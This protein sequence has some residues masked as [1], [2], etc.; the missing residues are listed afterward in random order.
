M[1]P[2]RN[3]TRRAKPSFTEAALGL[4]RP[5]RTMD[6]EALDYFTN[7][8]ARMGF[9]TPS[10]FS[11]SEYEL[12]RFSYNYWELITLYRNH[13]ISRRIV[14]TPAID[15]V[16]AWPRIVSEMDPKDAARVDRAIRRTGTKSQLQT[17]MIWGRLFGGAGALMVIDGQ[18]KELDRPLDLDSIPLGGYKGLCPFDRWAGIM[19]EG[20][21]CTD[22]SRPLDFNKPDFYRVTPVGGDSF[23]VHSSR[24]LR[25][26]GP[27][28]PTPEREAQT[29][30]GISVLEPIYEDIKKYDNMSWN[31][32]MLTYR[33]NILGMKFDDLAQLLSGVGSS[34]K[35]SAGFEKRM[36]AINHLMSNQS[37]VPLPKDGGIE[38]TQYSFS[39]LD[40]IYQ[41][42]Q[43]AISGG[44]QIPV[45][46]LWGRTYSGL[47]APEDAD[48]KLYEEKIAADQHNGML[49]Q[50]EQLYPVICM[51]ELGEVPD[52]LDLVFPSIRVMDDKDKGELATT[53]AN[54][55]TVAMNAGV[56]SKRTAAQEL[57][58]SSDVTGIFSNI[59]DE[60]IA[61][62]PDAVQ[63]ESEM[64]EG[65]FGEEEGGAPSLSPASSAQKVLRETSRENKEKEQ[66][67]RQDEQDRYAIGLQQDTNRRVRQMAADAD[68]PAVGPERVI[69]GFHIVIE[70]PRGY[71]RHGVAPDGKKWRQTMPYDYGYFKGI[72]GADGDSLDVA[73]GPDP[74]SD[75]VYLFDQRHLPD[76]TR[77]KP[78][79]DE[80]KVFLGYASQSDAL[81]AFDAGHHRAKDVLMDWTPMPVA[82]FKRWLAHADLT[83]PATQQIQTEFVQ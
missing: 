32:L 55:V 66:Q 46:R 10:L 56:I 69:H 78:G 16:R 65:L 57:K 22:P 80:T 25:C 20:E 26:M 83:K 34:Q 3:F 81:K 59:T 70:T 5:T 51:S 73:V 19:P 49:P 54:T 53:V 24:V 41:L 72:R 77:R 40:T 28:V 30:W 38:S 44:S 64:G 21:V 58:Q 14:D 35:A 13:W 82:E 50:L 29:W 33:A 79:F 61:S 17:A 43:L 42:F 18:E 76:G 15:M 9:G 11:G 1:A 12:I 31:I 48:E 45:S 52:D 2:K 62:L 60:F 68:G 23:L 67:E 6:A 47:G 74:T 8:P 36:S 7:A 75:W 4:S 37:L 39:G 27:E 71:S 63:D